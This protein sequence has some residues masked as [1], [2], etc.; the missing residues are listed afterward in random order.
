[1]PVTSNVPSKF[2]ISKRMFPRRYKIPHGYLLLDF[3]QKTPDDLRV[4]TRIFPK[5]E[6]FF[7]VEKDKTNKE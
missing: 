7:Y 2:S 4:R 1:M 3:K 5:E 6:N